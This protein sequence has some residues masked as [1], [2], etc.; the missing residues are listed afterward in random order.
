MVD[1][2]ALG[3]LTAREVAD[4][5][6]VP[7]N[8]AAHH[9]G[10]LERAGLIERHVSEGDRRRRYV[11]LRALPLPRVSQSGRRLPDG[12]ILFVCTHN[13]ARS[14]FAAGLWR[15]RTGRPA[16]SAGLDPSPRVHPRAVEVAADAGLDLRGAVPRDYDAVG[17]RPAVVVSV[18]DRAR[19]AG[20]PF[21]APAIHWSVPDPVRSGRRSAFVAAFAAV[22]RRV[23]TLAT[24]LVAA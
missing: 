13:S 10:I 21:A 9:L 19:E 23:D 1:A 22:S 3:D 4:A 20:T 16:L 2:L 11:V 14:Q 8:L 15:L 18:C 7:M 5:A 17:E 24:S 6:G 12:P